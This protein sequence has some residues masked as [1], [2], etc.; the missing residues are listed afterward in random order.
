M[1]KVILRFYEE[2]NEYLPPQKRKRDFEVRFDGASTVRE[3]IEQQGIPEGE[4]DL[5][6]VNGQSVAFDHVLR[7]GDRASVYPVFERFDVA[8][9]T[10]LRRRPLR[11]LRFVAEKSLGETAER[12][13]SMGFDVYCKAD[14]DIEKAMDISRKEKRI[15]LTTRAELAKS[16]KAT[17]ALYVAPGTVEN[18]IRGILED[19]MVSMQEID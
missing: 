1:P 8:G 6:L 19:L 16:E 17:H 7:G 2:L 5:V 4:V 12:M 13:N 10:R 3:I 9:V 14:L 18:E 11:N 15:L